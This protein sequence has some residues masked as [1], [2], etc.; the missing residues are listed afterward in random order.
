MAKKNQTLLSDLFKNARNELTLSSAKGYIPD[1]ITFCEHNDYLGLR[2]VNEDGEE[3]RG[4]RPFQ[5]IILKIF[6]RGSR[7]NENIELTEEEIEICEKEGVGSDDTDKGNLLKKYEGKNIFRELV[8][9]WGR[10]SGKTFLFSVIALYEALKLLEIDGGDP[11]K[12][13]GIGSGTE[14]SI[15]TVASASDQA[16]IA[17]NEI[18][19]K[20]LRSKYFSDKY[21]VPDG[22]CSDSIHL[23][24]PQD[25][26]NNEDAKKKG[27]PLKKGSIV[28]EVG[29]SNSNSLRGKGIFVLLLDEI[30]AYKMSGGPASDERIYTSLEPSLMTYQR[31]ELVL[32]EDKKPIFDKKGRPIKKTVFDTKIICISSP[33]GKEGKLYDLFINSPSKNQRLA[34]RLPTWVVNPNLSEEALREVSDIPEEQFMQEYGAEF[35]G[36]GGESFFPRESVESIFEKSQN[37]PLRQAGEPGIMYFA[38]ID[39]ACTSHNYSLIVLHREMY[40]NTISKEP[41]FR[42]VVDH[43]KYWSPLPNKPIDIDAVDNYVIELKRKF[44]IVMLTFDNWNSAKSIDK[45]KKHG[46]PYKRTPFNSKFTKNIY[47]ELYNLVVAGKLFIPHHDL[48]MKEMIYLQRKNTNYGYKIY[49]K[50]GAPVSTD[51]LVDS[52][53]GAC[54][55]A[56]NMAYNKLPMSKVVNLDIGNSSVSKRLWQS[57]SGPLGY[58]TGEEVSRKLENINAWN[59]WKNFN[60]Y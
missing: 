29:H 5:K 28:I 31:K 18:R 55:S 53:A 19:E 36:V 25:K 45:L 7:G 3:I 8:L 12:Y 9:V 52:L 13:Y 14:I 10:R 21:L 15:L 22:I 37:L 34:C 38:H 16:A 39:P 59:N 11:Y 43:I 46:I 35:S 17:F 24:T 4:L 56:T 51:D 32:D 26:I 49:I 30:A 33:I 57:M 27:L 23:L 50:P 6:Y 20:I 2:E 1:I 47:D 54:Y 42:I 44:F 40:L 58:G 60:K 41:D 48:L